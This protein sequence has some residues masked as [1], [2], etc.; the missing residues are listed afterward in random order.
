M[1]KDKKLT[2]FISVLFFGCIM[3]S[4]SDPKVA[5]IFDKAFSGNRFGISGQSFGLVL[6][7]LCYLPL[8]NV[9]FHFLS[10]IRQAGLD[11]A[12]VGKVGLVKYFFSVGRNHP[13]LKKSRNIT[14]IGFLYVAALV[15]CWIIYTERKGL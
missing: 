8:L 12:S 1:D 13:H 9:M 4:L 7:T 2:L 11:G 14:L 5:A 3:F 10:I 15:V 6:A